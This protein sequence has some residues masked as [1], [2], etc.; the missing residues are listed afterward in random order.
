MKAAVIGSGGW[1][2][3]LAILLAQNKHDV[4]LWSFLKEEYDA[5]SADRENR[6]FLP[7]VQ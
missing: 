7:G 3:A 6:Q 2:T 4:T 1:G 5:L